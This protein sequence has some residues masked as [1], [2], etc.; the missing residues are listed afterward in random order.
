[1]IIDIKTLKCVRCGHTWTPRQTDVRLC[2]CCKTAYWD[3]EKKDNKG[4]RTDINN[5]KK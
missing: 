5:D 2:P 3:V 1:M 4:K